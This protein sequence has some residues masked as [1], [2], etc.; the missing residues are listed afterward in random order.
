MYTLGLSIYLPLPSRL[1]LA[2]SGVNSPKVITPSI[3]NQL[4]LLDTTLRYYTPGKH[5][6]ATGGAILSSIFPNYTFTLS[7]SLVSTSLLSSIVTMI[8]VILI[9]L[10]SIYIYNNIYL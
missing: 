3:P 5:A 9:F 8:L 1:N 10:Y 6:G 7:N 4:S 2:S